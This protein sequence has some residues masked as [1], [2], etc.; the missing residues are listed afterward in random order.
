MHRSLIVKM[1]R[2]KP[3]PRVWCLTINSE[4]LLNVRHVSKTLQTHSNVP[5]MAHLQPTLDIR[6]TSNVRRTTRVWRRL[7]ILHHNT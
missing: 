3:P 1:A 2:V 5:Q 6:R 7:K 4:D